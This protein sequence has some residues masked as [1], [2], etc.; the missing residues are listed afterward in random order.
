MAVNIFCRP[1]PLQSVRGS[2]LRISP[3][4]QLVRPRLFHFGDLFRVPL[5]ACSAAAQT[6]CVSGRASDAAIGNRL[7][8][9]EGVLL[10]WSWGLGGIAATG[11]TCIAGHL[12]ARLLAIPLTAMQHPKHHS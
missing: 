2:L 4:H 12:L 10:S 6:C 5:V 7:P 9:I 3:R 1:I 11:A 8:C